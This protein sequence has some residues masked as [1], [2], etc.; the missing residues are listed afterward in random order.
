MNRERTRA[1]RRDGLRPKAPGP[2]EIARLALER[3]KEMADPVRAVGA[4]AYF[5]NTVR[6]FGVPAPALRA[7]A[8][9]LYASVKG[10]WKLAEA[11]ELCRLL[12]PRPE[13]EA[14]GAAI[15]IIGRFHKEFGPDLVPLVKDW[16]ERGW[17]DNWA[18]VDTFCTSSMGALLLKH[19]E[20]AAVLEGW[21]GHPDRWVKRASAVSFIKL[22]KDPEFQPVVYR[23]SA[24]LFPVDDDL[25]H[26]A[27]GWLLREAGKGDARSL[28]AFLLAN[29]PDIPRT[30]VRYAIERFPEPKR[31]ALLV[32]TRQPRGG[33]GRMYV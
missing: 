21:T 32:R 28:E 23:I 8:A 24:A 13:L 19:P 15:L 30:T 5:K 26:K 11:V 20:L 2:D 16:L 14:K 9:G 18:S 33:P 7:M 10:E 1:L 27:V 25:I 12:L 29:G 22:A 3:L 4:Q 17:L 6:C 31:R